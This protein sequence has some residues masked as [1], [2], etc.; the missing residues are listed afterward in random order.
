M[1]GVYSPEASDRF[2]DL[3]R[4]LGVHL[5]LGRLRR[6]RSTWIGRIRLVP[7]RDVAAHSARRAEKAEHAFGDI[8]RLDGD[9]TV[10]SNAARRVTVPS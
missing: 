9:G 8:V 6:G 10:V 5:R 7:V 2:G 1:T 3:A 4:D